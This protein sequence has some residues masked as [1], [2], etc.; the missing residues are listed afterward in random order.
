MNRVDKAIIMAAGFGERMCPVTLKIPKP[1]IRVNGV[2]MIDTV[3]H[4]LHVNGIYKIYVIVGYKKEQFVNLPVEYPGLELIENPYYEF[5][6][7]VS[8]LYVVRK[9]IGNSII[10]DGDQM[11]FNDSALSPEFECSGYNAVWTEEPTNEWL[12]SVEDG[13]VTHCS[14]EGG[15][16]GWQLYSISRWT[17]EDGKKLGRYIEIEF[18]EKRNYRIYWDDVALFCYPQNFRLGIRQMEKGD[19]I[20]LDSV[21][22][23]A[24]V[25]NSYSKYV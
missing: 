22:E 1:L 2:R 5:T 23:L 8:S 17:F 6:N 21:D 13:I 9:Y 15:K 7:N 12:M 19:I 10:L 25:D 3:I 16:G 14:R 11:V 18:E 4:G 20:E 24:T